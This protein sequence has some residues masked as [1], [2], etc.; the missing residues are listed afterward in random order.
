MS[1]VDQV[2]AEKTYRAIGR[3]IFEFSQATRMSRPAV[4]R[5]RRRRSSTKAA[6]RPSPQSSLNRSLAAR[7]GSATAKSMRA[8]S[9]L[10]A[11]TRA[12]RRRQRP[13][14]PIGEQ[15][16]SSPRRPETLFRAH[17]LVVV[18]YD[19][20]DFLE[21]ILGVFQSLNLA[22]RPHRAVA[23]RRLRRSFPSFRPLRG[24]SAVE[25]LEACGLIRAQR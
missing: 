8:G 2:A 16:G 5:V 13:F 25:A 15:K 12:R 14:S 9:Y 17:L 24:A 7:F 19:R 6:K 21:I 4:T 18:A 3:F 10:S 22:G 11:S 23:V 1:D 20:S